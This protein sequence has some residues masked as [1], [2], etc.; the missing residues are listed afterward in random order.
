MLF[1]G[2]QFSNLYTAVD[3][4]SMGRVVKRVRALVTKSPKYLLGNVL[5]VDKDGKPST[6]PKGN[7]DAQKEHAARK[8]ER[9][10]ANMQK[11]VRRLQ[12]VVDVSVDEVVSDEENAEQSRCLLPPHVSSNLPLSNPELSPEVFHN[13]WALSVTICRTTRR[14]P[15]SVHALLWRLYSLHICI[16]GWLNTGIGWYISIGPNV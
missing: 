1:I 2:T 9:E 16:R 15:L 6:C 12:G 10:R 5:C 14:R 4:P 8:A 3:T 7:P 11:Q 13:F